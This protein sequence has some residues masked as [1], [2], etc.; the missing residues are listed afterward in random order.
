MKRLITTAFLIVLS[1]PA[2]AVAQV[3]V[4]AERVTAAAPPAQSLGPAVDPAVGYAV[5]EVVPGSGVWWVTEGSHQAMF[6]TTGEGVI[7]ID[8]PPVFGPRL[9]AAIASVT[10][11]PVTHLIYSHA[12]ADHISGAGQFPNVTAVLATAGAAAALERAQTA[13]RGT[14]PFG[15][16]VGGG[17][18]PPVTRIVEDGDSLTVG[19]Q[20]LRFVRLPTSHTDGDLMVLMPRHRIAM[21]VDMVWAGW[22]PFEALGEAQ[23]VGGY[24]AAQDAILAQEWDVMVSGHVGRLATRQDVETNRAYV[25]DLIGSVL[26]ALQSVSYQDAAARAGYENP[27][28]TVETYFDMVA[29]TAADEV[30]GRWVG[31]L[32]GADVWTYSNARA[33]MMWLRLN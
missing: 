8:A 29:R 25:R 17:P 13:G 33:V 26:G 12:H 1:F 21:T 27:F 30:E 18:A 6:V 2:A 20:T 5:N 7:L 11:E 9:A 32:G 15:V 24:L 19:D 16:L 10:D 23:D 14:P 28:L 3:D 4:R 22:I 31:R